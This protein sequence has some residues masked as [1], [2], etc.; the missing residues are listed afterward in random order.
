MEF[1]LLGGM[2]LLM[3]VLNKILVFKQA[4]KALIGLKLPIGIVV[5]FVGV[6]SFA[7]GV[8]FIFPGIMGIIAGV[9]LIMDL[10]KLIP[11]ASDSLERVDIAITGFQIPIGILTSISAIIGLFM[12]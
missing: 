5:F 3:G 12:R 1:L 11:M 4:N 7:K 9:F 10:L 8:G 2:I 6:S